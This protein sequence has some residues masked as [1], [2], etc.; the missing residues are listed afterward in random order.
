MPHSPT[1]SR[2]LIIATAGHVDHGKTSLVGHITGT[3]TDTLAEEKS[4]GLTIVPGFAYQHFD[5]EHN[6]VTCHNTLGFVDVPGHIDFINNMLAGVSA[7]D[8][9][10]LVIAADDGIMPQT[11]EHLAI[12]DLLAVPRGV[13]ALT[14]IDRCEPERVQLVKTQIQELIKTT[15]LKEAPIFAV[16]NT[17][18]EGIPE[19]VAYLHSL[20]AE[21]V[22]RKSVEQGRNFRYLIDRSFVAKG[23]GTVLTGSVRTGSAK[24]GDTLLH[25]GS[26]K[27]SKLKGARLDKTDL[28]IIQQGQR[29]SANVS[30]DHKLVNRGDWLIDEAIYNPVGRFD[31]RVSFIDDKI[32]LKNNAQYHLYIGASHHVVTIRQ[33]GS[34]QSTYFQIKSYEPMIVH[35]GDRFIL[36]DPAS[37]NTI[38]GGKLIDIFVPR[39][40]RNSEAR[41]AILAAMDN[42]SFEAIKQLLQLLPEGIDLHQ[43]SLCRN[44]TAVAIQDFCQKLTEEKISYVSL[45]LDKQVLPV[46]LHDKY[47]SDYC[48]HILSHISAYHKANSNQQGISE[49]ALSHGVNF[50]GSHVLF[51]SILQ[52]L[53]ADGSIKRTGTLLHLPSHQSALSPEEQEF[54][55]RVR[56]IL[57]KAGNVPPRTR[58][59]VELTNIP[60]KALDSILRQSAK[61]GTL[62]KVADNRYYLPETI[63]A[64]AGFTEELA[65][66][67]E[68]DEGFSVVQF[69]DASK[70]GRNL[71]IEIL[72]YFDRA[73][74]TRRDGNSRF[75]RTD[76]ENV[77]G[78]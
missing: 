77:F 16:S 49:P 48:Q 11:R 50:A 56:P 19:L 6:G 27:L 45:K 63:M 72:E 33:L 59:L 30:L 53:V 51:H 32:T 64:L 10:M 74:F 22:A 15:S 13:I 3:D 78:K 52:F 1:S 17:S 42:D 68:N 65:Q 55:V 28:D 20:L 21:N 18:N 36:R 47:F 9:A 46:L 67:S 25:T 44:Y 14:K 70:I 23:I 73:G 66:A 58:E 35:Y 57:L 60:L 34:K 69:R 2:S 61:A 8:G 41:I 38:G 24:I 40:K 75:V 76:K 39:R 29:A 5:T 7:V 54:L 43:F 4:R 12:L 62:I 37:Q 71:C 31:A 26:G